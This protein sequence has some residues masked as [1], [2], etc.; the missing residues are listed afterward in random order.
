[1]KRIILLLTGILFLFTMSVTSPTF[2]QGDPGRG[3]E[4]SYRQDSG[5]NHRHV[6][7]HKKHHK[8]YKKYKKHK[9]YHRHHRPR[10][11]DPDRASSY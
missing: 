6:K 10:A 7:K 9:K 3:P 4:Q 5:T 1:M 2:A 11:A 8:K